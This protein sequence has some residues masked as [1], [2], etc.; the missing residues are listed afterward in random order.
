MAQHM[1]HEIQKSETASLKKMSRDDRTT[2][3]T[4]YDQWL[5]ITF[6]NVA[7]WDFLNEGNGGL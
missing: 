6:S 1:L 5:N 2:E 7:G 4:P 3:E